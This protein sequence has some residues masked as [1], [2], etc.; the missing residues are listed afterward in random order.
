MTVINKVNHSEDGMPYKEANK[1]KILASDKTRVPYKSSRRKNNNAQPF[2]I[3]FIK[4][5]IKAEMD[6]E[7]QKCPESLSVLRL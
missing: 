5:E 1:K 2:S 6:V 4:Q 3:Q 7:M